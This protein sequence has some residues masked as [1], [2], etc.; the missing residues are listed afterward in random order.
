MEEATYKKQIRGLY[1]SNFF[2]GIV[3]WYGIEKLFM[4]SIGLDAKAIGIIAVIGVS[5]N[6]ILDIPSGLLADRWSRK[7]MLAVSAISLTICSLILGL[8]N[9]FWLYALGWVFYSI[10]VVTTSGTYQAMTYDSLHENGKS[11]LYSKVNGRM[12]A[13]FLSGAGIGNIVGGLLASNYSYRL[14]FYMSIATSLI[15]LVI[16]LRLYEPTFHKNTQERQSVGQLIKVSKTIAKIPL[17]GALSVVLSLFAVV[18]LFKLDFGQLYLLRYLSSPALLGLLWAI[19]AFSWA[20]GG[21]LAHH[22][23]S[24]LT[25]LVVATTL[26]IIFMAFLDSWVSII[27]FF[28]QIVAM[29][30]LQNQIETHIQDETPSHLRASVLSVLSSVGRV[31]SIPAAILFGWVIKNHGSFTAV[32]LTACITVIILIYWLC[33]VALQKSRQPAI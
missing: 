17:L 31:V 22:F 12:Y 21:L 26:P 9:G 32:R 14:P 7:G 1:L 28:L 24:K 4:N 30:A 20:I 23:R 18:E 33:Y 5:L 27:F 13:L 25:L 15:N 8:S 11:A 19:Y 16:I 10:C 6:L 3:F 2:T 29:G